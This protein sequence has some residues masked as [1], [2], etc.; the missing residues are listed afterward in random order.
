[1]NNSPLSPLNLHLSRINRTLV[2]TVFTH[3]ELWASFLKSRKERR[4]EQS[5][6]L[7]DFQKKVCPFLN[8]TFIL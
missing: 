6:T 4:I 3:K 2:L 1:M 7:A 5:I 8:G